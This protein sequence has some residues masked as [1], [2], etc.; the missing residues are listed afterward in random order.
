MFVH[1]N[2]YLVM[3]SVSKYVVTEHNL[4]REYV[5]KFSN[6]QDHIQK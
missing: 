2:V 3:H 6:V 5:H 1:L 4:L